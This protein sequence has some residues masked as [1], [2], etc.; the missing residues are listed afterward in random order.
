MHGPDVAVQSTMTE[1]LAPRVS[2]WRMAGLVLRISALGAVAG[3]VAGA[4][5]L[6][7]WVLV[8]EHRALG[9]LLRGW[10]VVG[11]VGAAFGAILFPLAGFTVLRVIPLWRILAT[12]I[13]GTALGGIVGA[14]FLGAAAPVG[15]IVGFVIA[16]IYLAINARHIA[17]SRV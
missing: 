17:L 1:S 13:V 3:A 10:L 8:F 2:G 4:L 16:V 7:G 5:G 15:P 6:T 9:S 12:T 14:Q 11:L